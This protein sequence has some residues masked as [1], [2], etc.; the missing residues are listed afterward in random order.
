MYT[1]IGGFFKLPLFRFNAVAHKTLKFMQRE[2]VLSIFGR[3]PFQVY[4]WNL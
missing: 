1:D 2:L 4:V 3:I